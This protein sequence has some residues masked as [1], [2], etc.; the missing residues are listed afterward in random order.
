VCNFLHLHGVRFRFGRNPFNAARRLPSAVLGP[1]ERPPCSRQRPL[2]PWCTSRR[3]QR[4]PWRVRAPHMKARQIAGTG[5]MG[6]AARR[7]RVHVRSHRANPRH[8]WRQTS[9]GITSSTMAFPRRTAT[10]RF[11]LPYCNH[12]FPPATPSTSHRHT[13]ELCMGCAHVHGVMRVHT[14]TGKSIPS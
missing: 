4:V 8:H 11:L 6:V 9:R 13:D 3:W 1:V 5:D 10:M 7:S 12:E 2:G 14:R